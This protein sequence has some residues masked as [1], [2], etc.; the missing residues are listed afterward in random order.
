MVSRLS[1]L[2]VSSS[3]GGFSRTRALVALQAV[4]LFALSAC[5]SAE[6]ARTDSVSA[7]VS[8]GNQASHRGEDLF[9][10]AFPGTNGRS[11]ATCHVRADHEVLNPAHVAA[12]PASTRT[13]R[14]PRCQR[15]ST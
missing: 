10:T 7:A 14:P 15:T 2:G 12:T 3:G 9:E 1:Q 13:I 11:C 5:G 4:S 8:G 6:E